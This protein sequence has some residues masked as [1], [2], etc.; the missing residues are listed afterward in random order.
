VNPR[1]V[2]WVLGALALSLAVVLAVVLLQRP[3]TG[4]STAN[5]PPTSAPQAGTTAEPVPSPTAEVTDPAAEGGPSPL[6]SSEVEAHDASPGATPYSQTDEARRDWEPV[7]SGFGKAF[8]STKGKDAAAWRSSLAPFVTGKVKNQLATVDLANVPDGT[9][10]RIEP[11][12]FG[13]DK[14][15]VF[16]HYDTGLTLVTYLILDGTNW[17]IYAYDRWED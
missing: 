4:T 9:F 2:T 10:E 8:T 1:T 11:A 14:I 3:S 12:E 5:P 17:R 13:E 7:A 16:V 15:A 6:P